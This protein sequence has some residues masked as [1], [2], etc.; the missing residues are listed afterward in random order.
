[1]QILY[2]LLFYGLPLHFLLKKRGK[3]NTSSVNDANNILDKR[4]I[5]FSLLRGWGIGGRG[6]PELISDSIYEFLQREL[7][8]ISGH[9]Y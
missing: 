3:C 5:L 7:T 2:I 4:K 8:Q 9:N 6:I 1:M